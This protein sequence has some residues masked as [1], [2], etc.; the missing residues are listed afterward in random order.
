[1]LRAGLKSAVIE[2][3]PFAVLPTGIPSLDARTG[4]LPRGAISEISGP[5]GA[6][7]TS[8]ALAML[9]AT[10]SRDEVCAL[11]DGGDAFDPASGAAAGIDLPRLLWIRCHNLDQALH[12][13]DLLLQ[14]G[15]FGLAVMD[16]SDLPGE[17]VRRVPLS[18]WF[19][20]Q[21]V[22]EKTPT[23]LLLIVREN[24]AKS[25]AALVLHVTDGG[26]DWHGLVP[27]PS[28][29]TLPASSQHHIEIVRARGCFNPAPEMRTPGFLHVFRHSCS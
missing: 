2:T 27:A 17:A 24:I 23:S 12:S 9:A 21:R 4:G 3:R 10:T 14:G 16:L 7:K 6:G 29:G 5:P 22:I 18:A 25:A 26:T 28:H 8:I 20:F 13:L 19:R 11:V 1:M 15:G